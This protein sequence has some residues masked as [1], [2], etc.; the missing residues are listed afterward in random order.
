V[1]IAFNEP[2]TVCYVIRLVS[3]APAEDVLRE[4]FVA[5]RND[6]RS[7][8]MVAQDQLFRASDAWIRGLEER[9]RLNV[10]LAERR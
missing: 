9:Y 3:V 10:K 7:I 5:A 1:T 6:Q 2:R 4:A 8:A